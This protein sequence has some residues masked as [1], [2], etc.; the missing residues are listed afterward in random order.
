MGGGKLLGC[1]WGPVGL[2]L[3]PP[4]E[5]EGWRPGSP[6]AGEHLSERGDSPVLLCGCL[7]CPQSTLLPLP[8]VP[9]GRGGVS[10]APGLRTLTWRGCASFLHPLAAS[11]PVPQ[12]WAPLLPLLT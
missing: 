10:Q 3:S 8:R 7:L 2:L 4:R 1:I 6:A 12:G 5:A 9:G 11:S